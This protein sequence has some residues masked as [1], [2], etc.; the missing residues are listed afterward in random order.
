MEWAADTWGG[1]YATRPFPM[2]GFE[3][4]NGYV[5]YRNLLLILA[6]AQLDSTVIIGQIA[7][8][9]PDKNFRF[10]RRL[11]RAANMSG[12]LAHFTGGLKICAP[13]ALMAKGRLLA[14]YLERFGEDD[15]HELLQRTWSCYGDGRV[16]CGECGGCKQRWAAEML[17]WEENHIRFHGTTFAVK[18][19]PGTTPGTD[20]L[21]WLWS[22]GFRAVLQIMERLDQNAAARRASW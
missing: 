12:S 5:P 21:R 9:A 8:Y 17:C 6:A 3:Q 13:F 1:K 4:E 20:Y 15:T 19:T 2:G 18:P 16:H 14:R 11:E 22:G 10:Y 7:E